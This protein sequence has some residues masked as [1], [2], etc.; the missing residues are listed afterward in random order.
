[1]R[2]ITYAREPSSEIGFLECVSKLICESQMGPI[3]TSCQIMARFHRI[4]PS[5]T[6]L[7][8]LPVVE[9][10]PLLATPRPVA[11]DSRPG[12]GP[13]LSIS[14]YLII[15]MWAS[16]PMGPAESIKYPRIFNSVHIGAREDGGDARWGN[17]RHAGDLGGDLKAHLHQFHRTK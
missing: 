16:S 15:D 2:P 5:P 17:D 1:M 14:G 12:H 11:F 4:A 7:G 6:Y 13:L 3:P 10:I 9:A 8:D